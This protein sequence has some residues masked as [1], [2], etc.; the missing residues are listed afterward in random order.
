MHHEKCE[1]ASQLQD[2]PSIAQLPH[3]VSLLPLATEAMVLAH[4]LQYICLVST[5]S[6]D[7]VWSTISDV[8]SPPQ[9][10]PKCLLESFFLPSVHEWKHITYRRT[11]L[12][13][14]INRKE[15]PKQHAP[16]NLLSKLYSEPPVLQEGKWWTRSASSLK[17]STVWLGG[18]DV[19]KHPGPRRVQWAASSLLLNKANTRMDEPFFVKKEEAT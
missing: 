10:L 7:P 13:F 8:S 9:N 17:E 4:V 5:L 11:K 1:K 19:I 14:I 12:N 2:A 6:L 3:P 16:F 18:Y 15:D